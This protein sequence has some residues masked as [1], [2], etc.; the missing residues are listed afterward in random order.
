MNPRALPRRSGDRDAVALSSAHTLE[1]DR[2]AQEVSI[3]RLCGVLGNGEL[4]AGARYAR[5]GLDPGEA[6]FVVL[7]GADTAEHEC[8]TPVRTERDG[9]DPSIEEFRHP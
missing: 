1:M 9:R 6:D 7:A 3:L 4:D 2:W 8:M 5:I